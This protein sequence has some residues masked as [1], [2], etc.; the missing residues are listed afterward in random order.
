[1]KKLNLRRTKWKEFYLILFGV[2][3]K[4]I[5]KPKA[6]FDNE[7]AQKLEEVVRVVRRAFGREQMDYRDIYSHITSPETVF[8]AEEENR[9]LAMASYNSVILSGIPSLIVEG[10]AIAPEAQ[11]KGIFAKMTDEA[12]N[13]ECAVCLRTQNPR[14]YRALQKYCSF[15][16]PNGKEMPSAIIEIRTALADCINC[17]IDENGIVRDYYGG[18]F[19][20]EEPIHEKITS[21]FKEGLGLRLERGDALLCIGLGRSK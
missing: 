4:R 8:L 5:E 12:R 9:V 18:L 6:Y 21:F 7:N 14:M 3:I 13:G 10:I 19:Y 1:M 11:G 17:Q 16:Y 15:I 2:S 20:G